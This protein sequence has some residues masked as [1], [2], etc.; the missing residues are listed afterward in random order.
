MKRVGN[1]YRSSVAA[2]GRPP[3]RA[4]AR[5]GL[6]SRWPI[7]TLLAPDVSPKHYPVTVTALSTSISM[8]RALGR[9]TL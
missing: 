4:L 7:L 9:G 5:E 6:P 3:A 1:R 2:L 8:G